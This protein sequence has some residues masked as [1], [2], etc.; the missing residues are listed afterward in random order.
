MSAWT[1]QDIPPQHGR[2]VVITGA[3]GGLGYETAL[4]LAAV[5][6]ANIGREAQD[7]ALAARLWTVS[8]ELT[9]VTWPAHRD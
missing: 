1:T 3:T 2:K 4:A 6:E 5:G 7:T 8:E 9:G